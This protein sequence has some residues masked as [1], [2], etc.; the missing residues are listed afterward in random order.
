MANKYL[1]TGVAGVGKST[2]KDIFTEKNYDAI[3]LDDGYTH[4]V[5]TK[6]GLPTQKESQDENFF[7]GSNWM[8]NL[9]KF[10]ES[11]ARKRDRPLMVFGT[12]YDL[13]QKTDLFDNVFLLQYPDQDSLVKRISKRSTGFGSTPEELQNIMSFYKNEQASFRQLG[14]ICIDCTLDLQEVVRQIENVVR[15]G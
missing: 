13:K 11:M 10:E 3:D 8:L 14:A 12:T 2:L 7:E 6:T 9:A 4:W 1:V 5:N 15:A